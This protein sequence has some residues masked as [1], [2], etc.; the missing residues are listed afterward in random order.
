M[1]D[2][3]AIFA[4]VIGAVFGGSGLVGLLFVYMRRFIDKR[5][6]QREQEDAK[7]REQRANRLR[8]EDELE[9]AT[10]RLLFYLHKAVTTGQHNGDLADAWKNYQDA[11]KRMKELDRDILVE[12]EMDI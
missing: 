7:H 6:E 1:I 12:H 10:G 8:L 5:L 11:E 3:D 9:H 4:A 2:T